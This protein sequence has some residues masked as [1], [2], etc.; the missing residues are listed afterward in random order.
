M[1]GLSLQDVQK[2][3]PYPSALLAIV[4]R[5]NGASNVLVFSTKAPP[6]H[7]TE[8]HVVVNAEENFLVS[9]TTFSAVKSLDHL[10]FNW[11]KNSILLNS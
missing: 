3:S 9:R 5:L 11:A 8:T 7:V 6:L 10:L 1:S 4:P 2:T